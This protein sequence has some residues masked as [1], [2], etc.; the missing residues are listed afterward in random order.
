MACPKCGGEGE[1]MGALGN[2]VW[3]KCRQCGYHFA[4]LPE[5]LEHDTEMAL[6]ER[7]YAHD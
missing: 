2:L 3:L 4:E 7:K 6:L 1:I 5:A